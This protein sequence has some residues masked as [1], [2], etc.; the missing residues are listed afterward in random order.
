VSQNK[1]SP[2]TVV[3]NYKLPHSGGE[4]NAIAIR[5]A[6]AASGKD[7]VAVYG[8]HGWHDWYLAA[9]LN[10]DDSL[11]GHLEASHS[12]KPRIEKMNSRTRT[13]VSLLDYQ[14]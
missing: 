3:A 8:D 12:F 5:M 2:L 9:N 7:K 10:D 11:N 13:D 1:K 14:G 6:R 4:A